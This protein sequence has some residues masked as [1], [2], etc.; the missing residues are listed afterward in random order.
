MILEHALI[1]VFMVPFSV[2]LGLINAG[3]SIRFRFRVLLEIAFG[4]LVTA[5]CAVCLVRTELPCA[6]R[7]F[8]CVA[9]PFGLAAIFGEIGRMY[10]RLA[11]RGLGLDSSYRSR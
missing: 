1:P 2:L 8:W 11:F 10:D 7:I 3:V 5:S 4:S 6:G 9:L